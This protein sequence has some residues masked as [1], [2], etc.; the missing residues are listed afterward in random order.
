VNQ[1]TVAEWFFKCDCKG[2]FSAFDGVSI[3]EFDSE[4]RIKNVKEFQSK[5]EHVYP[6]E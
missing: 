6:Y 5:A 1:T 4:N 2:Q 3:I